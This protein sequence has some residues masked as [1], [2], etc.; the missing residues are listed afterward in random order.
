M[1]R[2]LLLGSLLFGFA[3]VSLSIAQQ[4]TDKEEPPKLKPKDRKNPPT[5]EPAEEARPLKKPDRPLDEG[6][7]VKP[8][9]PEEVLR[10]VLKSGQQA[11]DRLAKKEVDEPTQQHQRDVIEG[12]DSLIK[13]SQ[14]N[15]QQQQSQS[16]QSSQQSKGQRGQRGQ[17]PAQG[18]AQNQGQGQGQEQGDMNAGPNGLGGGGGRQSEEATKLAEI[19]KDIWGHLPESLRGEMNAY[20]REM[21]MDKYR[22]QLKKYYSTISEKGR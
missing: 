14:Q 17:K 1:H 7:A 4:P 5:E 16:S 18:Q 12:L 20:S 13:Q 9:D 22:D 19:Y 11:D 6:E 2:L 3:L 21:F 10:K 8:I 15:N